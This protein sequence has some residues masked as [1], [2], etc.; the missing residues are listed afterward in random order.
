MATATPSVLVPLAATHQED[1]ARQLAEAGGALIVAQEEVDRAPVEVQ[2]L[3]FDGRR[4][5]E[6]SEA[7]AGIAP[8]GAAERVAAV[9]KEAAG[10]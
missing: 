1:N 6:M 7:A 3:L 10:V 8:R 2:Q 9:L 4:L 5:G